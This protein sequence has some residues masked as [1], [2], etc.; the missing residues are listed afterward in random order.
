MAQ[1]LGEAIEAGDYTTAHALF[2]QQPD[3]G[4]PGGIA[5][6]ALLLAMAGKYD[7][8]EQQL[9]RTQAPAVEWI[10]RG[11]RMRA[12]RWRDPSAAGR[13]AVAQP[14]PRT[15]FYAAMAVA[16]LT[17]DEKLVD[18]IYA[19]FG[20]AFRPIRGR[21]VF[22]DGTPR[23]FG[24]LRDSD[25]AIGQM[26]EVFA[27]NHCIYFPFEMV[28]RVTFEAPQSFVT[29]YNP[30]CQLALRDGQVVNGFAPLLYATSMQ[31]S[32][33]H[34]RTGRQ[35]N[36]SYVGRARRAIGQRDFFADGSAMIGMERVA[37]IE[38]A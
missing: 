29:R 18:K 34:L 31:A 13:L 22:R 36:F 35:T 5:N 30:R 15:P 11:D 26:L 19:D 33:Q 4:T 28:Q 6:A 37:A 8:A 20:N 32:S 12:A 38:F 16:L 2:L 14:T 23:E 10:V 1:T 7:E 3:A 25:D 17:G 27:D 24:D 21:L 9:A